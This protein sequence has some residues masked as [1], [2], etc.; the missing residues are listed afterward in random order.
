LNSIDKLDK[1]EAYKQKEHEKETKQE[2]QLL[3]SISKTLA[4][5]NGL[6]VY[7]VIDL[8]NLFDNPNFVISLA[9][10]NPLDPF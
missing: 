2:T 1:L 8:S 5:T 6:L 7:S 4:P 3:V 10:Y 9:N